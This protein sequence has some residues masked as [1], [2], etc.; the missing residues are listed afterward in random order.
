LSEPFSRLK[1]LDPP[2]LQRAAGIGGEVMA[3]AGQPPSW[4]GLAAALQAAPERQPMLLRALAWGMDDF[5]RLWWTCLAGRLEEILS[6]RTARSQALI[7]AERWYRERDDSVRYE[8]FQRGREESA[9]GP[10]AMVGM[11][12]FVTGPSLAPADQPVEPPPAGLPHDAA[13]GVLT[14]VA[15]SAFL[16]PEGFREVNRVGLDIANGGDGRDAA[17]AALTAIQSAHTERAPS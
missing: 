8:A 12:A 11:A 2:A 6:G 13:L 9:L 1:P 16:G 4:T 14:A 10:S 15:A 5:D 7:Q 3:A 17:R